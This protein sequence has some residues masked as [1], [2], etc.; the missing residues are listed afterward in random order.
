VRSK[1]GLRRGGAGDSGSGL[2]ALGLGVM[3]I[4]CK[5]NPAAV[6]SYCGMM[7]VVLQQY[8]QLRIEVWLLVSI[9]EDMCLE[10]LIHS[11]GALQ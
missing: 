3:C 10:V 7:E 11:R 4:C 2:T 8:K 1:G 5:V 6:L 9:S